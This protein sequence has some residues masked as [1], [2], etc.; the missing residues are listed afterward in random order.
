M[1]NS[2]SFEDLCKTGRDNLKAGQLQEAV[3]AFEEARRMNDLDPEVHEG[4]ATA[5]FLLHAYEH[6]ARHFERVTRLDP[7]RGAS[8]I[9]L[10]AVYN[11]MGDYQ[12]AA[13][14]LR[15]A[16]Q[17]EKKSGVGFY[18]LGIAYKHLK[19]WNLAVPAY[20]EAIRL[21]PRMAD[22]YLNLANVYSELKNFPQ[23]ITHYKKA[24]EL[25]PDLERAARG[26]ERAEARLNERKQELTPFGRLVDPGQASAEAKAPGASAPELTEKEREQDRHELHDLLRK[27][28]PE[29]QEALG[30]LTEELDPAVRI[31]NKM[32]TQPISPHGVSITKAE[33]LDRFILARAKYL[34]RLAKL[35]KTIRQLRDHE[36]RFT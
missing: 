28:G 13:E 1:T 22:A 25:K 21:E 24:L 9:N 3:A 31:L 32:L 36:A 6:A 23:A 20:R 19:Q 2:L 4:L 29:L 10:G 35:Q 11:R 17:V 7:R 12:K 34:P 14:V 8:W 18:N 15:R 26:L 27:M 5:H 16:V 33:A 30:A